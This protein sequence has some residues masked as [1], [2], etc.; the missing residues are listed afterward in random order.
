MSIVVLGGDFGIEISI[1]FKFCLVF[2]VDQVG[3]LM[4]DVSEVSCIYIVVMQV[5]C[6]FVDVCCQVGYVIGFDGC[7][8][9]F[10][11]VVCLFGVI[12]VLGLDVFYDNLKFVENVV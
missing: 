9:I 7:I 12:Q 11:D 4:L 5:L 3:V 1:E 8:V 10:C 6:V 2:L